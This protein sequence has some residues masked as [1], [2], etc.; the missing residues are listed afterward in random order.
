MKA[1]GIINMDIFTT[2]P[3]KVRFKIIVISRVS[4]R[5]LKEI[6]RIRC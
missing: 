4:S 1:C 5:S 2:D 6:M 3:D